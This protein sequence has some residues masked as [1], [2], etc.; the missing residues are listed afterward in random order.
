[1]A[2]RRGEASP[3]QSQAPPTSSA[4]GADGYSQQTA[5]PAAKP[6]SSAARGEVGAGRE[7]DPAGQNAARKAVPSP[8]AASWCP[9]NICP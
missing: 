4:A 8:S 7:V 1:M 5:N 9:A 6:K 3:N 2:R